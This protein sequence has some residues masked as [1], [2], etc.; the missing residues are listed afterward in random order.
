MIPLLANLDI[1]AEVISVLFLLLISLANWIKNRALQK[2]QEEELE[3][4]DPM[5][6]IIWRRQIGE[7]V[8]EDVFE[9][10]RDPVPPPMPS[11][12]IRIDPRPPVVTVAPAPVKPPA[13]KVRQVSEKEAALATKFEDSLGRKPRRRTSHRSEVDKLLRSPSA[14]KNAILLT[15]ILGP[16]LA[17]KSPSERSSA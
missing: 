6:E 2:K 3:E 4:E 1:P 14:A 5:R 13:M 8:D 7:P 11:R 10:V 17:L 12:S 9:P 16:P 15:E